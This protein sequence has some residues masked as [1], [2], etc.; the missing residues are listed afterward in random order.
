MADGVGSDVEKL[1]QVDFSLTSLSG[2]HAERYLADSCRLSV[3]NIYP[4]KS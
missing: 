4:R 2:R 1:S 3:T